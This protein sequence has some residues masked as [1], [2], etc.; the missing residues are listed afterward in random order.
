[1]VFYLVFDLELLESELFS[2]VPR[3]AESEVL[4]EPLLVV[5]LVLFRALL[6]IHLRK[7]SKK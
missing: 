6:Q 7:G 5:S 3:V 4:V 2:L 1:M